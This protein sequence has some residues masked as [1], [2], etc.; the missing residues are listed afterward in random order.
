MFQANILLI[1]GDPAD[2]KAVRDALSNSSDGAIQ[3]EWVKTCAEGLER[4]TTNL[5]TDHITAVLLDLFLPDGYGI[6]TFDR[7]YGAAPQIPI[8]VLT[9]SQ[10]EDLARLAVQHGA[11]DYLLKARLDSYLLPKAL[12]S[13]I[14]RAANAEALFEEKERAQVTLNSIGDAVMSSDVSGHVTYLNV[15]AESLTGWSREDAAGHPIEDVFRIVDATT[16]ETARNPLAL[17][18]RDN[19]TVCLTPNCVLIRRDGIEVAIEDSAA[20]IHDRRGRVTGAVMVFHDVSTTRALS[21]RMSYLAQHDS[22]TGLP[23]RTLLNDRL[24]QAISLAHRHQQKLAVLFL[25]VD[26]FKHINDSLGHDIGDR[27][28]QSVAQRLCGCVRGSD[29]V[30]RLGGDEFVIL[31]A[32]VAHAQDAAVCAEKILLALSTPCCI[33]RHKLHVTA[34]IGI[35][36]YPDDGTDAETLMK[37][38][39]FAMYHAKDC[40]RNNYQFFEPDMNLRALERQSLESGLRHAFKRQQFVLHYQPIIDLRT[41]AIRGVEALLRWRHPQRGLMAPAQFVPIAEEAG[42]IVPVGRWVLR[43]ACRQARAW[44]DARLPSMRIAINISAV[45]LREKDFVAGVRAILSETGLLPRDLELELTETFLMQD[46]KSTAGVLQALKDTGV[47]LALD[48]F[49]TGYSSLS[50]LKRFPID[51]LKIDRAFVRDLATSADDA[52]IVEAVI[53]M[54]RS[55]HIAVV[56]EGVETAEQLTFLQ[57]HSCPFGQGYYFSPPVTAAAFGQLLSRSMKSKAVATSKSSRVRLASKP[58]TCEAGSKARRS[59]S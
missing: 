7:L 22:L 43:E 32:E 57:E 27:L 54:G 42:V 31:L 2:A 23:N 17:A 58:N 55:L 30:S 29:T 37:H 39:D 13:M 24:T 12:R 47:Q 53:S 19:K 41:H 40:G 1:Q 9:A 26:R 50:H 8:L 34:S 49:G 3:V 44:Q 15:A 4:L 35:V 11:Q 48:D 52:C 45:E 56:A 28:L 14:E 38:A 46:S 5:R 25:D 6:E 36:I 21:L 16:R 59:S 10:H 33:D 20:P 51:T 18:V